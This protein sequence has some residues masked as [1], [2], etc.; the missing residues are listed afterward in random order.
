M[1]YSIGNAIYE[2]EEDR[3]TL[4]NINIFFGI[5]ITFGI[6]VFLFFS[7]IIGI[8]IA[9]SSGLFR[10]ALIRCMLGDAPILGVSLTVPFNNQTT[11]ESIPNDSNNQFSG[12][13]TPY[14]SDTSNPFYQNNTQ[15]G[16]PGATNDHESQV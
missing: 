15:I 12:Y 10:I 5:M 14:Y 4:S 2:N 6:V 1:Y 7:M 9:S 11:I 8:A 16:E 13:P 3:K